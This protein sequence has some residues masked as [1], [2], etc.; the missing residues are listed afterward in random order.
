M[1]QLAS[2]PAVPTSPTMILGSFSKILNTMAFVSQ[3]FSLPTLPQILPTTSL[4][5]SLKPSLEVLPQVLQA[6][7]GVLRIHGMWSTHFHRPAPLSHLFNK[8]L[9]GYSALPSWHFQSIDG[10]EELR[11]DGVEKLQDAVQFM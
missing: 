7:P 5:S 10:V 9:P 8:L 3:L 2:S 4:K 11:G 1:S 6:A